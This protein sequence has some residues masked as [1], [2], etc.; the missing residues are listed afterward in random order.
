M[1]KAL[2]FVFICIVFLNNVRCNAENSILADE[3]TQ[4]LKVPKDFPTI[5]KA[6]EQAKDGDWVIVS[7]GKYYENNIR[8][9]KAVTVSSEWKINGDQSKIEE[10]IID[11]EDKMLF[12]IESDD[13][14]ISGFKII[15]GDHTLSI[16]AKVTVRYNHFINNLDAL[17]FET[18]SGGYAGYNIFRDD[19]DDGI[20]LD[21]G[22][23]GSDILIEH[24]T[25]IN[26][27][28]DGIEIRLFRHPEQ[29]I[30][31]I[32]R[33]NSFIGNRNA[34]IQIISYDEY[35]GKSFHIH[36]NTFRDNKV[37]LG[38]MEGANTREDLTGASKMDEQVYFYNN[39]IV[40]NKMGA[41]GGN[42]IIAMNNVV[43]GNELGGFKRFGENSAIINNLFYENGDK[44]FIELSEAVVK[45]EN[46]FGMN[47][48]L[49][50]NTF[51]PS[52]NSPCVDAGKS[53]YDLPG[54][55]LLEISSE[56]IVGS[57]PDI[58]AVELDRV[59]PNSTMKMP[60]IVDAGEDMV[61]TSPMSEIVLKGRIV[62]YT[63]RP[64]KSYWKLEK[65][66]GKV[67]ILNPENMETKII[68]HQEGIY[69]LSLTCITKDKI[70][71]SDRIIIRYVNKGYG[72]DL[73]LS[74]EDNNLIEAEDFSYT[75]SQV[76]VMN[77]LN[78]PGNKFILLDANRM[79]SLNSVVEYSIGMAE[80]NE[81]EMW[82]LVKSQTPGNKKLHVEF[83]TKIVGEVP[84]RKSNDF[85]WVKMR[86]KIVATP[87]QWQLLINN[88]GGKVFLDK[89]I[90]TTDASFT[91]H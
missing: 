37:G 88:F 65:G 57:A 20:D 61:L 69:Q 49:D 13:V 25:I 70:K 2:L 9:N 45:S 35:T 55:N 82:F 15:N 23:T 75:Y 5:A 18:K 3:I 59:D 33:E 26:S 52:E 27:R 50:K 62:D 84:V 40:G 11:S 38:C 89:I 66:E 78:V 39:T 48:L 77:D 10:T 90:L 8:I 60:L 46:L 43:M 91:P 80:S 73:F 42:N 56:Y 1:K 29:N 53:K 71:A 17:S 72:R 86:G 54:N 31:Y 14:E 34:G 44:D 85:H 87:G 16:H 51:A 74:E 58:G 28:D 47:P 79:S 6:I 32:I 12:I 22:L 63:E 36:H 30:N 24:N 4:V 64:F 7:P 19:R 21:I 68:F 41:T 76:E 67:E 83:N 81:Y